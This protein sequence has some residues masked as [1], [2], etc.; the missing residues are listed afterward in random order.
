MSKMIWT[1]D[2]VSTLITAD[3]WRL[4][5]GDMHSKAAGALCVWDTRG[6]CVY[7]GVTESD[8]ETCGGV[9]YHRDGCAD[10]DAYAEGGA[11]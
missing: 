3:E 10:A 1:Q 8:C 2:G 11:A 6:L 7:C 9:G 5:I 4:R